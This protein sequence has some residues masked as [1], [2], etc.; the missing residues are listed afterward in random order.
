MKSHAV[1]VPERSPMKSLYR[2][3]VPWSRC[4][5][6]KSHA[7][8]VPDMLPLAGDYISRSIFHRLR[9]EKRKKRVCEIQSRLK[10]VFGW[11]EEVLTNALRK[12]Y[13][14]IRDEITEM[15]VKVDD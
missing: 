9:L 2:N 4:T 6:M 5:G 1:A 8:A 7:V 11:K 15:H 3:E 10:A 14:M 12:N 13:E